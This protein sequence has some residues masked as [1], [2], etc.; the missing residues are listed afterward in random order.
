MRLNE[1]SKRGVLHFHA[2][3]CRIDENGCINNDYEIYLRAQRATERV[4]LK[5]GWQTAADVRN[6]SKSRVDKNDLDVLRQM[7]AR[8]FDGY[9]SALKRKTMIAGTER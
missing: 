2:A 7:K 5:R 1:K 3:V 9:F 4:A 6:I 8:L